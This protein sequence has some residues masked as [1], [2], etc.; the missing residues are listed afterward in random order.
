MSSFG[1]KYRSG[2]NRWRNAIALAHRMMK[3]TDRSSSIESTGDAPGT[4]APRPFA[5]TRIGVL[6]RLWFTELTVRTH[7][8][9]AGTR[10]SARSATRDARFSLPDTVRQPV[11]GGVATAYPS[12]PDNNRS[13]C[14]TP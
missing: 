14:V 9:P 8:Q 6:V 2:T 4:G 7:L 1:G 3:T 5:P 12:K 13:F 10:A 11:K